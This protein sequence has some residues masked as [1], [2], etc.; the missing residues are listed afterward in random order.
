[1][2]EGGSRL[3]GRPA[4]ADRARRRERGSADWKTAIAGGVNVFA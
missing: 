3:A 4:E 1:M 2:F